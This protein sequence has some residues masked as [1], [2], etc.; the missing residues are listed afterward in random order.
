MKDVKSL[1]RTI[2]NFPKPGVMFRDITTLLKDANG[3]RSTI[4][5]LTEHFRSRKANKVVAIESRG[6]IIGAA[7]AHQL[8]VGFVPIRKPGKLP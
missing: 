4:N 1:I 6:F 2:P 3:F 7:V 8:N 5:Q